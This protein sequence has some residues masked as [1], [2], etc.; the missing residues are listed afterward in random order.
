T[1]DTGGGYNVGWTDAGEW[2]AYAVS[3]AQGGTFQFSARVASANTNTK[4]V[5]IVV[6]GV[7]L[8]KVSFSTG[9]G[10]Q[11]WGNLSLGATHLSTGTHTVKLFEDTGGFNLNYID[12]KQT[13]VA[14]TCSAQ[15]GACGSIPDGCG[16]TE[17]CTCPSGFSCVSNQCQQVAQFAPVR[18]EGGGTV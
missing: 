1:T 7:A 11:S 17:Q 14:T 12:V 16:G 4:T 18:V 13:C 6:D 8:P 15:A 5:H 2:L 10:W 9:S 3:V